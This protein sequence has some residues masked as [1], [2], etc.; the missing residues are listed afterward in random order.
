[1]SESQQSHARSI[2]RSGVEYETPEERRTAERDEK[3]REEAEAKAYIGQ[4]QRMSRR[5]RDRQG[6]ERNALESKIL[7]LNSIV[8]CV[9]FVFHAD[10]SYG[11]VLWTK[12]VIT[13]VPEVSNRR[14]G[15]VRGVAG[16]PMFGAGDQA[17]GS[18]ERS[19][20]CEV[21]AARRAPGSAKIHYVQCSTCT[22]FLKHLTA[23]R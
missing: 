22:T 21:E 10:I 20:H 8:V 17:K 18:P 16:R 13:S 14:G 1:M 12:S 5:M 4:M 2:R 11:C 23:V 15:L 7:S 6:C 9:Q 3:A 19:S